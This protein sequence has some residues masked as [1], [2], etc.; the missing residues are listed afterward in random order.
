LGKPRQPF[1]GVQ[2]LLLPG[3]ICACRG[4]D[5]A[6]RWRFTGNW[7]NGL[8]NYPLGRT[9]RSVFN[10]DRQSRGQS[11]PGLILLAGLFVKPSYGK[12]TIC[13]WILFAVERLFRHPCVALLAAGNP[14]L[15]GCRLPARIVAL[16]LLLALAC[17]LASQ[18]GNAQGAATTVAQR[19]SLAAHTTR[20]PLLPFIW[21][22]RFGDR[23][24][25]GPVPL[26]ASIGDFLRRTR[27]DARTGSVA[28]DAA[29]PTSTVSANYRRYASAKPVENAA[30]SEAKHNSAAELRPDLPEGETGDDNVIRFVHYRLPWL[31]TPETAIHAMPTVSVRSGETVSFEV[32]GGV[33][34][35]RSGAYGQLVLRF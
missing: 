19:L 22:L 28:G 3:A 11:A 8:P 27:E 13:S 15:Y 26:Y 2:I 25:P 18:R 7:P 29:W 21:P 23:T 5:Q 16:I 14:E 10:A 20:A 12:F 34:G 4:H 32:T 6:I 30:D 33:F 17:V 35:G 1:L 31:V 24:D 9:Y